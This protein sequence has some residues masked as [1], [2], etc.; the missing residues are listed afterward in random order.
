MTMFGNGP[1]VKLGYCP[2]ASNDG[3]ARWPTSEI[4]AA[5]EAQGPEVSRFSR[6]QRVNDIGVAGEATA[7]AP[8]NRVGLRVRSTGTNWCRHWS[9]FHTPPP[10]AVNVNDVGPLSGRA[11]RPP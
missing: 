8:M 4:P 6:C 7:I 2:A 10:A 3:P 1:A 5:I 11:A 9:V